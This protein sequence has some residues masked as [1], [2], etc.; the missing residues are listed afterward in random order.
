MK[1]MEQLCARHLQQDIPGVSQQDRSDMVRSML[2][3]SVHRSQDALTTSLAKSGV[4]LGPMLSAILRCQWRY[5]QQLMKE[6]NPDNIDGKLCAFSQ[7][8]DHFSALQSSIV[9]AFERNWHTTLDKEIFERV[10]AQCRLQWASEKAVRLHN[11]FHAMPVTATAKYI[12]SSGTHVRIKA[13]EEVGRVFSCRP[14]MQDVW[15]SCRDD[16]YVLQVSL[17]H[18][19][20]ND[21]TLDVRSVEEA[22]RE[23]RSDVRIEPEEVVSV[24]LNRHGMPSVAQIHDISFTG[25]GLVVDQ[26]EIFIR[27]ETL[28]C[29]FQIG[30]TTYFLEATVQWASGHK[31]KQR[32][33]LKFISL[34]PFSEPLRKFIFAQQQVIIKRLKKLSAPGWMQ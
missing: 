17:I 19:H 25:I 15:I 16:R 4:E 24:K 18:A 9:L 31:G 1:K 13:S 29:V 10:M 21:L 28:A 8:V 33:G 12:D 27:G 30:D 20:S 11:Y 2:G 6:I 7:C 14:D 3:Q 34:G 23:L 26:T 32:T 5:I 22:T